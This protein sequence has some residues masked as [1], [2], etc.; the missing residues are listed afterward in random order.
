MKASLMKKMELDQQKS[1]RPVKPND[2]LQLTVK[3]HAS[4]GI[5]CDAESVTSRTVTN[6]TPNIRDVAILARKKK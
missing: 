5:V 3:N 4:T 6:M 1:Q 2:K